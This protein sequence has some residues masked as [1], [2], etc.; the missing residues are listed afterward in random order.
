MY[1]S[2]CSDEAYEQFKRDHREFLT[3][4]FENIDSHHL[5]YSLLPDKKPDAD[6]AARQHR[7]CAAIAEFVILVSQF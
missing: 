4:N 3:R 2:E 6:D 7:L 5:E 1:E